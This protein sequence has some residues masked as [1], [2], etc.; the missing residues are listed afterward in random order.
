MWHFLSKKTVSSPSTNSYM[1][2]VKLLLGL[3]RGLAELSIWTLFEV[4]LWYW[5]FLYGV[6][7]ELNE[8]FQDSCWFLLGYS[9]L[10]Q[11]EYDE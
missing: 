5:G 8:S 2:G 6:S 4:L 7:N 11:H 9:N 3:L 10:L 1:D